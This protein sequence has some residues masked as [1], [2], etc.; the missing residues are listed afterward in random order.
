MFNE[1]EA[2]RRSPEKSLPD[3]TIIGARHTVLEMVANA[4]DEAIS[5][6]GD[7]VIIRYTNEGVIS[8][9]DF[10]RGVPLGT[11][12]QGYENWYAIYGKEDAGGKYD[13]YQDRLKA[14]KDWSTFNPRDFGYLY[15]VGLYGIGASAT[16]FTSE[17]FHVESIRDGYKTEM[18]FK[19]GLPVLPDEWKSR[20]DYGKYPAPKTPCDAHTGTT[21]TWIPDLEV[22]SGNKV[23]LTFLRGICEATSYVSGIHAVL[24]HEN[25]DG[26]WETEDYPASS[27]LD[28]N[29]KRAKKL[30]SNFT[31]PKQINGFYHGE[32]ITSKSKGEKVVYVFDTELAYTLVPQGGSVEVYHNGMQMWG[33]RHFRAIEDAI[34]AF[35][36]TAV[37]S[38]NESDIE[39]Y[40]L[41]TVS[42][43]SNVTDY[44]GTDKYAV[45]NGFV[46]THVYNLFYNELVEQYKHKTNG[47]VSLVKLVSRNVEDRLDLAQRRAEV[48]EIKKQTS[49]KKAKDVKKFTPSQNYINGNYPSKQKGYECMGTTPTTAGISELIFI[50][51]DSAANTAEEGRDQM[52]QSILPTTGKPI[53]AAKA[54]NISILKNEFVQNLVQLNGAGVN[55]VGMEDESNYDIL[56]ER[57]DKFIIMTDADKDGGHIQVMIFILFYFLMPSVI[58]RGHLY[59]GVPPLYKIRFTDG[60]I[61]FAIDL[62]ERN[63]IISS[64]SKTVKSISRLKGLGEMNSDEFYDTC[65]N[66]D[67]RR[68]IP[69]QADTSDPELFENII[70]LFGDRTE[71]RKAV[72][73]YLLGEDLIAQEEEQRKLMRQISKDESLEDELDSEL[74]I[75]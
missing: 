70:Q 9:Q 11:N 50:E 23:G 38:V 28:L 51:G 40:F 74:Y 16:Q 73:G 29:Y 72:F 7:K 36:K 41:I 22:F 6:F 69:I 5:G 10:G 15:S 17:F 37:P 42:S 4:V 60:T 14:I 64:E 48:K 34:F 67:K 31:Q 8:V 18:S 30:E 44:S 43:K 3:N 20:D 46:Y 66:P 63:K 65:M 39:N 75:V 27:I 35:M 19:K 57:F 45:T 56:K 24:E 59:L 32:T 53:N 52:Y 12:K 49:A 58:D 62:D 61:K 33:G 1:A 21:V 68:L 2:V 71:F 13:T 26:T 55:I 54:S 47:I 25:E